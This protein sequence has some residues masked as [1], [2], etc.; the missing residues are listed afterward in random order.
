MQAGVTVAAVAGRDG[1]RV[2]RL[3]EAVSGAR[4]VPISAAGGAA[5]VVL[6]T[7]ADSAIEEVCSALEVAPGVLIAHASGSRDIGALEAARIRG[8]EVG[9]FHPLAAV[10]RGDRAGAR[11]A[12]SYVETFAGAA[13][14]IEGSAGVQERLAP[15]ALALGGRPFRITGADKPLYHLGASML[16]AFSAG[17][18]QIAWDQMRRAGAGPEAASAG[19]GH[20][21]RTVADN[22][23]RA[24]TPATAQTGPVARGDP[25]GVARQAGVA[26]ALSP[27]AQAVYRVH[28]A[29]AVALAQRA[30]SITGDTAARLLAVL[31]EADGNTLHDRSA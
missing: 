20:L 8:A 16:A 17:L 18:A 11:S 12:E 30:G 23:G 27:E 4:Q 3:A 1:A 9:S 5:P 21:L 14:A 7:V 31:H 10:P 15:L 6:L 25:A 29:H 22:I 24:P 2:R 19:V 28:C 13:F 26:R